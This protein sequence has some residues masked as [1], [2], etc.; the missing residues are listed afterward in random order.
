MDTLQGSKHFTCSDASHVC[1]GGVG[2]DLQ[3]NASRTGVLPRGGVCWM[4]VCAWRDVDA[5]RART[6]PNRDRPSVR[7]K[8][9]IGPISFD[10]TTVSWLVSPQLVAGLSRSSCAHTEAQATPFV[11][12]SMSVLNSPIMASME[13]ASDK[14]SYPDFFP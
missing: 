11:V 2:T 12:T 6:V 3:R 9:L 7:Y 14:T 4:L 10:P 1:E 8:R 5:S 13:T